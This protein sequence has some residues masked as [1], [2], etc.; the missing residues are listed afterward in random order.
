MVTSH[1]GQ[2]IRN[3]LILLSLKFLRKLSCDVELLVTL[4]SD[5]RQGVTYYVI[6]NIPVYRGA[7]SPAVE[8]HQYRRVP[9]I[10]RAH[11]TAQQHPAANHSGLQQVTAYLY[12]GVPLAPL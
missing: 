7:S 5:S 2:Q 10:R 4:F 9:S 12:I 3:V 1:L 6:G 8:E 11:I